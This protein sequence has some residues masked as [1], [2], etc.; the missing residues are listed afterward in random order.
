MLITSTLQSVQRSESVR[1]GEPLLMWR[2]AG[3][4]E[5]AATS[6]KRAK[7]KEGEEGEVMGG[8]EPAGWPDYGGWGGVWVG[9]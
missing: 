8:E 4:W 6:P 7:W 3:L 1:D 5:R 2:R 9:R